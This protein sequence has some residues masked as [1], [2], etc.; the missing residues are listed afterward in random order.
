MPGLSNPALAETL[1][2]AVDP[3]GFL[4]SSDPLDNST[5]GRKGI[6]LAGT[7]QGPKDIADS[8]AQAGQ[9]AQRAARY[10]RVIHGRSE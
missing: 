9:A 10:L 2:L 4:A 1:N 3:H 8:I 5:T 7:V 6:F